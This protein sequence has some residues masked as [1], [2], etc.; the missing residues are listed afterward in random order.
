[1]EKEKLLKK[2]FSYEK[3]KKLKKSGLVK[4]CTEPA[5]YYKIQNKKKTH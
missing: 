1:M 3:F 2:K 4:Q 5:D